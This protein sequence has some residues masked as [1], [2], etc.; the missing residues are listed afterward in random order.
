MLQC[1]VGM[2]RG[3]SMEIE[4]GTLCALKPRNLCSAYGSMTTWKQ[5]YYW[6][7]HPFILYLCWDQLFNQAC[8]E[9]APNNSGMKPWLF[10]CHFQTAQWLLCHAIEAFRDGTSSCFSHRFCVSLLIV[11]GDH[12]SSGLI[13]ALLPWEQAWESHWGDIRKISGKLR[14]AILL[15]NQKFSTGFFCEMM[16]LAA[17]SYHW[18]RVWKSDR[19]QVQG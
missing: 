17:V 7:H 15:G 10:L 9:T 18:T 11:V 8:Y 16:W 13:G 14:K 6:I 3:I 19:S 1:A 4:N 5:F 2:S 12:N